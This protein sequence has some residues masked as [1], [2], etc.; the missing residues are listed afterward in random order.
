MTAT[1]ETGLL[2]ESVTSTLGSAV[3]AV[4]TV[5]DWPLPAFRAILLAGPTTLMAALVPVL[6]EGMVLV[7]V[8]V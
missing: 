1:P 6:V 4:P 3:T 5:A 7:A 2:N 8:T